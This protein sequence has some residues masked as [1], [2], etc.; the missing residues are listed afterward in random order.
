MLEQVAAP[1]LSIIMLGEVAQSNLC[2][3]A[4]IISSEASQNTPPASWL[5][6]PNGSR[7]LPIFLGEYQD[8][9]GDDY[10]LV[11]YRNS[12]QQALDEIGTVDF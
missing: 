12:L 11:R 3:L 9:R 4:S 5:N 7:S 2:P 1:G 10:A 8:R 6:R